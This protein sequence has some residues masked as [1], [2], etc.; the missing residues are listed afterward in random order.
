MSLVVVWKVFV[1]EHRDDELEN[2]VAQE[3]QALIGAP[4]G[5]IYSGCN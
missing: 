3:L 4:E 1:Q 2:G 5:R